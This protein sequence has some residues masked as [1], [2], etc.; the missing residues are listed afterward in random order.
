MNQS[1]F[2]HSFILRWS[3]LLRVH[4]IIE[5]GEFHVYEPISGSS[6]QAA[7]SYKRHI[8]KS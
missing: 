6:K 1:T 5:T 2:Y 3:V 7:G 8:I 4:V